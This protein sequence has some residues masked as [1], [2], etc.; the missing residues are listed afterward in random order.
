MLLDVLNYVRRLGMIM[1]C[2]YFLLICCWKMREE[3]IGV[4][5]LIVVL[6]VKLNI[7]K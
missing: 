3:F 5:I 6:D 1:I 2:I 7:V 4:G